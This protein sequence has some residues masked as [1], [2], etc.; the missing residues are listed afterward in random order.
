MI[1]FFV[2]LQFVG[3]DYPWISI[4]RRRRS[5]CHTLLVVCF[6]YMFQ[7][8][9][10]DRLSVDSIVFV[11]YPRKLDLLIGV[12]L[13]DLTSEYHT[14]TDYRIVCQLR[15]KANPFELPSGHNRFKEQAW[16]FQ[17][18]RITQ[19]PESNHVF[20]TLHIYSVLS[21]IPANCWVNCLAFLPR[22]E[23]LILIFSFRYS[24]QCALRCQN[25]KKQS[26]KRFWYMP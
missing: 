1:F 25:T 21:N 7:V 13:G 23:P 3:Q 9:E 22:F 11:H 14:W 5:V 15:G 18:N 19:V 20:D 26:W 24:C 8:Y 6:D 16:F 17:I 2:G 10:N 4:R 12:F